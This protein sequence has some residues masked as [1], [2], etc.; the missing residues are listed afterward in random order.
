MVFQDDEVYFVKDL[1]KEFGFSFNKIVRLLEH[2]DD[3]YRDG[4]LGPA[5]GKQSYTS[6][7]IRGFIAERLRQRLTEKPLKAKFSVNKP[8]RV[9]FLSNSGR[10]VAKKVRNVLKPHL[11]V[12]EHS[13]SERI[14]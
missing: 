12:V 10:R 4:N 6:Y 14:S 7:R 9:V 13:V 2:D 8:R 11:P 1:M 5:V 3:V